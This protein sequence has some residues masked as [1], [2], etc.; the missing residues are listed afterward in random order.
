MLEMMMQRSLQ[1][2]AL[3]AYLTGAERPLD[4]S[5]VRIRPLRPDD[6]EQ[7]L[8][9]HNRLSMQTIYYRYL[10]PYQ[11]KLEDMAAIARTAGQRGAGF[12]LETSEPRS[13][14][15]GM[16]YYVVD[17][18]RPSVAEPAIL[19]E[20][21]YQGQGLGGKLFD[22]LCKHARNNGIETFTAL[23]QA[24]NQRMF[25]IFRSSGYQYENRPDYGSHDVY[26]SLLPARQSI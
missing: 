8:A 6:A 11:P 26:L 9:M 4:A 20:D 3:E 19:I 17:E 23:V 14:I 25:K 13:M 16:G 2:G 10:R 7:L 21:R 22:V 1:M 5:Q 18:K 24:A 15:V 12:A